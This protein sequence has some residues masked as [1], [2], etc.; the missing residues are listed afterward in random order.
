MGFAPLWNCFASY[1][2]DPSECYA[3]TNFLEADFRTGISRTG[4]VLLLAILN[5]AAYGE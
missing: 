4:P 3:I 5:A 1:G 2:S